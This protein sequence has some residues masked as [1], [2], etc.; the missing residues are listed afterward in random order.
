MGSRRGW[1]ASR[2]GLAVVAFSL[3]GGEASAS[4]PVVGGFSV[5]RGDQL[6]IGEGDL[7]HTLRCRIRDGFPGVA[8]TGT[9][10]LTPDYLA[11]VDALVLSSIATPGAGIVP[12]APDEQEALVDFVLGGRSV[13]IFTDGTGT[14]GVGPDS[15]NGSCVAPFGFNVTGSGTF[16]EVADVQGVHP[17]TDGPFGKVAKFQMYIP[18]WFDVLADQAGGLAF[19]ESNGAVGLAV[20]DAG[21]LGPGSG[22]VVVFTDTSL[23]F[24][25]FIKGE[26]ERLVLNALS[27]MLP[28]GSGCYADCDGSGALDLFDFLCFVNAFNSGDTYADCDRSTGCEVLDLF[29]F[30]CFVNAFNAGC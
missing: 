6:S 10:T 28:E 24:D 23:I 9:D 13:I 30:L 26:H 29:D 11:G 1:G 27:L 15:P 4:G 5:G 21:K 12:L 16:D 14:G 8:F 17:I 2:I 25:Q 3:A 18:G 20:I 7:L 22:T 19:I